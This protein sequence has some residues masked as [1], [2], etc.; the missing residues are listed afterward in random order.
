[1]RVAWHVSIYD[2]E[3]ATGQWQG[4]WH[5]YGETPTEALAE[6]Y[7]QIAKSATDAQDLASRV[8]A[9]SARIRGELEALSAPESVPRDV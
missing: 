3:P 6:A 9:T 2:R 7:E 4:E 8:T 5:G 1:M